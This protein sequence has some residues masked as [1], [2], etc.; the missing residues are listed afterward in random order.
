MIPK[1][2]EL[3]VQHTATNRDSQQAANNPAS[4]LDCLDRFVQ[5]SSTRVLSLT[6]HIRAFLV[7]KHPPNDSNRPG[8]IYRRV[9]IVVVNWNAWA[10]ATL[11]WTGST[12]FNRDLRKVAMEK[13]FVEFSFKFPIIS[14]MPY[15]DGRSMRED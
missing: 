1:E 10:T 2:G 7:F 6:Q 15:V 4:M 3:F 11:A 13:R 8:A 12:Q 14:L 5:L 9:D